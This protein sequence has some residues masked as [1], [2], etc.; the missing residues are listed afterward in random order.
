[1]PK[2]PSRPSTIAP[3]VT[4][5][6]PWPCGGARRRARDFALKARAGPLRHGLKRLDPYRLRWLALGA[7][8]LGAAFAGAEAP[9]R[10]ARAFLPDPG[11]LLGDSPLVVEAWAAPAAYTR[12][13]PVS[14]SDRLGERVE[15][16]PSVEATVRVTGPAGAPS[17]VFDGAGAHRRARFSRAADGAWE[18]K[19]AIPGAGRLK[20][21]R[22]HTRAAWRLAPAPDHAP[23][24][25][26]TAPIEFLPEE[27][28]AIAW[29]ARD[30]FG[31][32]AIALRVRPVHPPLSLALA[33]ARDTILASP[34]GA[35]LETEE[36]VEIDLA[37]HPYAGMEVRASIV[38]FDALGQA[39]VSRSL[40]MTLPQ[41]VF[42]QPL[43]RAA[44]EVR[45]AILMERRPYRRAREVR[46][47][48]LPAGDILFG[49]QRIGY[50][51]DNPEGHLPRAPAGV[52]HAAR[53]IDALTIAPE[54]GYFRDL[55]VFAGFKYARA[56]LRTVPD[57]DAT[58]IGADTL[59]RTALRAEYGGAA[60]T[61]RALDEAVR[62]L[63]EAIAAGAKPER[64]AQL[65]QALRAANARHLEALRQEAIRDGARETL[66]D[67]KESLEISQQDID[68]VMAQVERLAKEGRS[69]EAQ[70]LLQQLADVL[71][72]LQMRLDENAGSPDEQSQGAERMQESMD[73]LSQA[74]GEQ[75]ELRDDSAEREN[76]QR[77]EGGGGQ[78]EDGGAGGGGEL[79]D[80]QARLR[81]SLG[82]AQS[83]SGAAGAALEND[84]DAAAEA[85][86][87]A[88][89][90]L[91]RGDFD[92]A[93]AAQDSALDHLREGADALAEAMRAQGR[94]DGQRAGQG[95]RDPLGRIAPGV[96]GAEG[97]SLVP[98]QFD[99]ARAREILDEIRRRAGEP[100]RPESEREYLRRLLDRF[101]G[102]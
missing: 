79:A 62:A 18:A 13:A 73:A 35:P 4:K 7:C 85:M 60:D 45:S 8:I 86:M 22:F 100:N 15:T 20:I 30:D 92:A 64:I 26:F 55:A 17:L 19:L 44:I 56:Q 98:T 14:L 54:D 74:I 50:G 3:R 39:G 33:P 32:E 82:E 84:L 21:V 93:S 51:A 10:L 61:R 66:E 41:K 31:V 5:A 76:G 91:R 58:D 57:I 1:M 68:D 81:Q 78:G 75:R 72:N 80:R 97:E 23:S 95:P 88:E 38:A 83:E 87:Q 65:A 63:S 96:S 77:A 2:T 101:G 47:R 43:A 6:R 27:H 99:R 11:P 53:L 69:A 9:E 90:A 46:S 16:P 25:V 70:A 42:L 37:S 49:N 59:W 24:A 71:A 28:G 67:T 48:F 102:P 40:R 52:R 12:A 89:N 29:S 94:Q 36:A 34:A